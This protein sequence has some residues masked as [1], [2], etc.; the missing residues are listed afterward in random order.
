[1]KKYWSLLLFVG[2]LF[3]VTGCEE[4]DDNEN[5]ITTPTTPTTGQASFALHFHPM[6]GSADF[7]YNTTYATSNGDQMQFTLSQFYISELSL[8]KDPA[9]TDQHKVADSYALVK[10]DQMMYPMGDIPAG[11]YYGV[12][13]NV[14]IDSVTNHLDPAT[15][16]ATNPLAPQVPTMHWSWNSGYRFIT[17]EGMYDPSATVGNPI[18]ESFE[19]HIG[20][21]A[22][23]RTVTL[24]KPFTITDGQAS[25]FMIMVDHLEFLNAV[26]LVTDNSTHTMDNMPLATLVADNTSSVFSAAP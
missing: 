14:G 7:S 3:V 15:Y 23:L 12:S 4:D 24:Q 13:F 21:D 2:A 6:A 20:M 18:T 11:T 22:L 26:D 1:M 16:D 5:T 10:P 9:G 17:V 8:W 19:M 25:E